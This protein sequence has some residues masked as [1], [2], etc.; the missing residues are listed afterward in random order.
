[1]N[2][3]WNHLLT[4]FIIWI[5]IVFLMGFGFGR[6]QAC[7]Y[8]KKIA[9]STN[10]Q[11]STGS[12]DG[13]NNRHLSSLVEFGDSD[14]FFNPLNSKAV[15]RIQPSNED[16]KNSSANPKRSTDYA[17][18]TFISL[19]IWCFCVIIALIIMKPQET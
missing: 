2:Y 1:M 19:Y 13:R 3:L 18:A 8:A 14:V 12:Y 4:L 5:I 11:S 7:H 15:F 6:L 9:Q 10:E 16:A 17:H